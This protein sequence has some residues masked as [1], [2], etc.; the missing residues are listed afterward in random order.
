MPTLST[1]IQR[2]KASSTMAFSA[3]AK[4]M[5][6]EGIDVIAMTAG[7]PDFQPPE[8]VFEAAREAIAKGMTKYT[9]SEGTFELREAV[10]AKFARENGVAFEPDQILVSTGGKQVLY[11][12]FAA[13]LDP[14]DEV[15]LMAPVGVSYSGQVELFGGVPV[16]VQTHPQDGFVPELDAIREAVSERTKVIVINSP[17]NPTG[18]VYPP[19]LVRAIV[20]MAVERDIWVFADD[21]YEHL[22]YDGEFTSVAALAPEKSLTIH[23]ASKA[24]A[25][26]G[27]RIGYG[28]GPSELIGA[29]NRL[30]GQSTS[31]ANT[32]AQHAVT[33][34]LTQVEATRAFIDRTLAAYRERRDALVTGLNRVGLTTP[35]PQGAFYVMADLTKIDPDETRAAIALLEQAHVASVPGTDFMAPG[36]A[37]FSYATSLENIETALERIE[38]FLG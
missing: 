1:T 37:R 9:A 11:N 15:V 7:E 28:A 10:C 4:E 23:G 13:V 30:Q 5:R 2:L 12:G 36:Q 17:S 31:G 27:W 21:L 33:A 3:K 25:L 22:I 24:Y 34:A 38:R 16:V 29:M 19:E 26:T 35:T 8:H 18:A 6:R 32:L 20:E 14:G